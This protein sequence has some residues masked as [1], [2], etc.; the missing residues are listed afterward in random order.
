M[1]S[2]QELAVDEAKIRGA[3]ISG[4]PLTITTYALPHEVELYIEQVISVFLKEVHREELKDYLVYCVQEL[5]VNAKKANT[6]RVYF[7][8]RGLDL[9]NPR[10]YDQGIV[11]FKEDTL[12]NIGHYLQLQKEQD[13]YIKVILQIRNNI[14]TIEVRNNVII[15]AAELIR[16]QQK[17]NWQ[18]N[19]LEEAIGPLMDATEGAG[20]GLAILVQMLKKMG[21]N[22]DSFIIGS[23]DKETIARI[24]IPMDRRMVEGVPALSALSA[25]IVAQVNSLPQFPENIRRVQ[26]LI[27][28]PN[29]NIVIIAQKISTDPAMTADLLKIVNSAQYMLTKKVNNIAE[30]VKLVG[31]QGIRNLLYSYGTLKV[32]G[33]ESAD[34]KVLWDHSYKTAFYA[35]NLIKNFKKDPE[36]LDDVYVGGILHD[37]GKIIFAQVHPDLMNHIREF[38]DQKSLPIATFE[39]LASG[40]DHAEIGAMVAEKWNFSAALI[41]VI[42]YHHDPASAPAEYR[43]LVDTVYLANMF[44]LYENNTVNFDQFEPTVLARFGLTTK[45]QIDKLLARFSAGFKKELEG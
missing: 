17:L 42:R 36:V 35:F 31:I 18:F 39:Y 15:N 44:C 14:I 20:L 33:E 8:E 4:A 38:C 12:N 40:M 3:V 16:I 7:K 30:A 10:D 11:S 34:K 43:T 21:L 41:N 2:V 19:N 13:L 23:T 5:A 6:K 37:M 29:A 45:N 26:Q 28:Q 1:V 22:E 32:L 27:R 24:S 9:V 25:A